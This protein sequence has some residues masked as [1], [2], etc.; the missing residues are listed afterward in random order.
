[1]KCGLFLAAVAGGF[2]SGIGASLLPSMLVVGQR[3][4]KAKDRALVGT[5]GGCMASRR[6]NPWGGYHLEH[7]L[8]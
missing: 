8:S 2:C 6:E 7:V 5:P 4:R 3:L 1:M